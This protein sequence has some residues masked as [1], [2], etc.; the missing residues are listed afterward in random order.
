MAQ[1]TSGSESE[2]HKAEARLDKVKLDCRRVILMN[3]DNKK[4]SD[5]LLVIAGVIGGYG[6]GEI[7]DILPHP[8]RIKGLG[9]IVISISLI[10]IVMI[11]RRY[12]NKSA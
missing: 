2:E 1:A 11:V 9:A 6:V 5:I 8:F 3:Y 10:L 4:Y 7:S 12:E